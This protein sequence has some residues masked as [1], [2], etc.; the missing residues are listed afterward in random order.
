MRPVQRAAKEIPL[1]YCDLLKT[2]L[3]RHKFQVFLCGQQLDSRY[4]DTRR[5]IKWFLE[6]RFQIK[7]FL[8]EDIPES[9]TPE[10]KSDH[11]T[12][13]TK[14]AARAHVIAMFLG[15][16]GTI[17][18]LTAF[19]LNET[20]RPKLLVFNDQKYRGEKT[21]L[22]LGPLK[23]LDKDA[24]V[25]INPPIDRDLIKVIRSIDLALARTVFADYTDEIQRT[26]LSFEG[27]VVLSAIYTHY[28]IGREALANVV[29]LRQKQFDIA[30]RDLV[31]A[32]LWKKDDSL[33]WPKK[34]ITELGL[35]S[36]VLIQISR[37]R[38]QVMSQ[39]LLDEEG[40]TRYRL[41]AS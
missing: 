17:A 38:A 39:G 25:W 26:D 32:G 30:L 12:I 14:A 15:S 19:A 36:S 27:F 34:E 18:E 6:N 1:L 21:F 28:P 2:V 40:R 3:Q 23:L 31:N 24:V 10:I 8:G 4:A 33:Y 7:A 29:P 16:P 22:N 20:I 13:E 37:S 11:L 41:C 9:L 35:S 5:Q